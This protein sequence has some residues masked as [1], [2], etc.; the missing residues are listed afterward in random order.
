MNCYSVNVVL[1]YSPTRRYLNCLEVGQEMVWT[2]AHN[3]PNL[4]LWDI[5]DGSH[6][7]TINT[8]SSIVAL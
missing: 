4:H 2:A 8:Y 1:F 6:R 5:E 3:S 7:K